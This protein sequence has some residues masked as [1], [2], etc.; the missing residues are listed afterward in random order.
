[1]NF[2][3]SVESVNNLKQTPSKEILLELYALFKQ[4]TEGDIPHHRGRPSIIDPKGRAK[5]DAWNAKKGMYPNVA[6]LSYINFVHDLLLVQDLF[7][8][9]Q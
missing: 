4:A 2:E 9:K 5:W 6:K 7:V 3:E 8:V 1:M